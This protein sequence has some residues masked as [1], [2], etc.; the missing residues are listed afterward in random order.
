MTS[1][2]DGSPD[3]PV[4]AATDGPEVPAA[5]PPPRPARPGWPA[6]GFVLV[7]LFG[8]LLAS[9]PARNADLWAHLAAGRAFFGGPA[10]AADGVG[11]D[12]AA[13]VNGSWL[14][15]VA[16]FA[17]FSAAGGAGLVAAK[18]LLVAALALVLLRLG[19]PG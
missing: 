18:A 11:A 1:N 17:L 12:V 3:S 13:R 2:A 8:F 19:R 10:L 7:G 5:P 6:V 14:W 16:A 15:N 9:F 4:P